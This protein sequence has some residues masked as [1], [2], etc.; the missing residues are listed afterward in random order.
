MSS[1]PYL[2]GDPAY[3]YPGAGDPLP[4][5][6]TAKCLLL[7]IGGVCVVGSWGPGNVAWAPLPKRNHE[8]EEVIRAHQHTTR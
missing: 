6:L 7:T 5:P 8:K 4:D 3:R 2:A 1:I